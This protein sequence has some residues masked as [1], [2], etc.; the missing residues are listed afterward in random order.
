VRLTLAV[1]TSDP[2]VAVMV[3]VDVPGTAV[4]AA[5]TVTVVL[6]DPV[7]VL[8]LKPDVTFDG[9]PLMEKVTTPTKPDWGE[10]S[11]VNF[12]L[13]PGLTVNDDEEVETVKSPGEFTSRLIRALRESEPLAA[14]MVMG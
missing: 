1:W 9:S 8:E 2:L 7:T 3:S 4:A 13:V 6:P 14:E 10:M 12:P 11:T 5:D